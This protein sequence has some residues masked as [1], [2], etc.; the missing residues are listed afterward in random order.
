MLT[1]EMR[2]A[3]DGRAALVSLEDAA[4]SSVPGFI[5]FEAALVSSTTVGSNLRL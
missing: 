2:N 3:G 4:S 1:T 5:E